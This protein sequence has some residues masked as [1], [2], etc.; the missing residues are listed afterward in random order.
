[1]K[2][3]FSLGPGYAHTLNTAPI[4]FSS[5]VSFGTEIGANEILD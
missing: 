1:M 2:I 4:V 3:P 5:R